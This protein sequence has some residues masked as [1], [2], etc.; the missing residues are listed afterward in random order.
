MTGS[1]KMKCAPGANLTR[2][3]SQEGQMHLPFIASD[4]AE[5]LPR[6]A[7]RWRLH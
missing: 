5:A 7:R 3:A 6:L 1:E 4:A 2:S